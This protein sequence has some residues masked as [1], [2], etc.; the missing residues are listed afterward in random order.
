MRI[1]IIGAACRLPQSPGL[2][3]FGALLFAGRDAVGEVPPERWARGL[4]YHPTDG[5]PGKA[6]TTAAGCIDMVDQFDP[7]FFSISAREAAHIDPQQRLLL[8][9]AHEAIEDSGVPAARLGGQNV[10]V[11]VGGSSWDYSTIS[12]A[13]LTGTDNYSMQ[14][15][16]LSSMSNRLSYYFDLR[17]PSL[18]VDTAC[19]SSLVALH[20]ACESLRRSEIPTA[21]VGG[22]NLLLAPHPFV[23]FARAAMLSHRGRCQVFD[24]KADGY[25]RAEGGGAV[26][27]KPLRTALADG[28]PIRGV[29]LASGVNSDGRTNGFSVPSTRA[30]E[31]LLREVYARAGI[32]PDDVSYFE[33]HGTGTPV[34]DP[35][36]ANA[37]GRAVGQYRR[38]ALP[39]GSVKSNVGHLEAASGMAGLMKVI[40]SLARRE[41]PASLHFETPNP[42]IPF[43]ALNLDVVTAPRAM[44]PGAAGFVAGLN[45]FG[46]GG[47]NAHVVLAAPPEPRP[48]KAAGARPASLA[49]ALP[50]L[51]LSARAPEALRT[52]AQVWQGM[53]ANG[54]A[55]TLAPLLRGAARLRDHYPHRLT[56]PGAQAAAMAASLAGWLDNVPGAQSNGRAES[57]HA[58]HGRLAFVFSGNGSQWP[59]MAGD[60]I[61]HSAPFRK[62]LGTIDAV[63]MP[64]LGWS[65]RARFRQPAT[66]EDLRNS[67]IAQPMLFAVQLGC[68]AALRAHGIVAD[69]YV[70]HSVGEVAA[71][72]ASGAL[73]LQQAARVIVARSVAQQS[74]HGIGRMAVLDLGAEAAQDAIA[75]IAPA[76]TIAAVN[77]VRSVTVAGPEPALAKLESH[78]EA[79][80]WKYIALDLDYAFHSTLMDPIRDTLLADLAGLEPAT[81]TT[82]LVSTVTGQQVTEQSSDADYWWRNVR[83]P[84]RF[85]DA[86]ET[87]IGSGVH[88]FVEIG[89]RPV[90]QSYL[91]EAVTRSALPGRVLGTLTQSQ[92][93][94]DPF[95]AIA[96]RCYVAGSTLAGAPVFKGPATPR[97]LPLYPWQRERFWHERTPDA[98]EIIA[99]PHDHPLL[100]YRQTAAPG[101]WFSHL[102]TAT[103]P[104]L[105]DHVVDG[106]AVM[107][108]AAMIEMALAAG[109]ALH[110]DAAS[111]ELRDLEIIRT[112]PL[113]ASA[114]RQVTVRIGPGGDGFTIA[115]RPRLCGDAPTAHATGQVLRG[116]DT[117]TVFDAPAWTGDVTEIGAAAIYHAATAMRLTYGPAFR[118]VRLVLASGSAQAVVELDDG[119][120]DRVAEGY[121]IDPALVDGALQGLIGLASTQT[122]GLER[123]AMLP[124]RF[125]RVRLLRTDGARPVRAKLHLRRR[126][127]RA[128][129]ADIALL[130]ADGAVVMELLDCWFAVVNLGTTPD[131][132]ERMVWTALV[133]S[134]TQLAGSGVDLLNP[135]MDA[136]APAEVVPNS[137]MLADGM[138]ALAARAATEALLPADEQV[139]APGS[140]RLLAD[141]LRWL[142]QDGMACRE[143][144]FW[145]IATATDLPAW[146]NVWQ[147]LLFDVPA[148][149]ADTALAGVMAR[150]LGAIIT[151]GWDAAPVLPVT[152]VDQMLFASPTGAGAIDALLSAV[153]AWLDH[154]PASRPLR[155]AEIC[156]GWPSLTHRLLVLLARRVPTL[157]YVALT[158][159]QDALAAVAGTLGGWPGVTGRV[160]ERAGDD[161]VFDLVLGLYPFTAPRANAVT[162]AEAAALL[163][164]G[165]HLL[166]IEPTPSRLWNL[167]FG[168]EQS[169][170]GVEP[171]APETWQADLEAA[172]SGRTRSIVLAGGQLWQAALIGAWR[173]QESVAATPATRSNWTVFAAAGDAVARALAGMACDR[174][175]HDL[176]ALCDP[177]ALSALR[178]QLAGRDVVILFPE[179]DL[180]SDAV[181]DVGTLA[182]RLAML[183]SC[184]P[185]L[186]G[187]GQTRIWLVTR[188]PGAGAATGAALLGLLR[189]LANEMPELECCLLRLDPALSDEAASR[190]IAAEMTT[191]DAE[192]EVVWTPAGRFVRRLR[193]GSPPSDQDVAGATRLAVGRPG[194]LGSLRWEAFMPRVP[195]PNEVAIAVQ[196]AGLNFRDLMWAQGVL[197]EEALMGGFS[198]ASLG[199]ECAGVVTAVGPGVD[200]LMPGMRVIAVAPAALASE[201]VTL[202]RAVIPMPDNM[203]MAEG[204]TIPVAFMTAVYALGHLANLAPGERVLIHGGLGSLGLAAIQ[205]ALHRDAVV[206]ATAGSV[207]RRDLL[208]LLGVAGVFDSRHARFAD[209]V[210]AATG[211]EGVD[212]VLNSLSGELM[213]SGLRVLRP[214]GRFIE[215]GKRDLY[216]NTRLG[217]RSLRH[218][219]AYFAVDADE[220]AA[221]RPALAAAVFAEIT[222]LLSE[223]RLRPLPYRVYGSEDVVDAFRQLQGSGHLG[224]ILLTPRHAGVGRTAVQG[225]PIVAAP[226]T[227]FT[228]RADRTYVL[229]GAV[230]GFGLEA[231][232]FLARHGARHIALLGRRGQGTP[233]AEAALGRLRELGVEARIFAC[234]VADAEA[235][236]T[237]LIRIRAEMPPIAGV[238]HAAMVLDDAWA[239]DLDASRF[240]DVLRPKLGGAEALDRLTRADPLELFVLFSSI[241]TVLG[242]PGQANY[243]AANAAMEAVAERRRAEGLPALAVIWGPIGD[244]GYLTRAA[245][246]SEALERLLGN[247]HISAVAALEAL[248]ALLASGVAVCGLADLQWSALA[249]QM[250]G[251]RAPLLAET[252]SD[253]RAE[254]SGGAMRL[255]LAGLSP[256]E[257]AS[258]VLLVLVNEI[259]AILRIDP[260]RVDPDQVIAELGMDSLTSV[261][262]RL[263]L[264]ARLDMEIP[265]STLSSGGTLR[266]MSASIARMS[267]APA[268]ADEVVSRILQFEAPDNEPLLEAGH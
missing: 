3:A 251:L 65:V 249:R 70:G 6:Y 69:A 262:L 172:G 113:E 169:L 116:T 138:L 91:R 13:D 141:M 26:L 263:A 53:L 94:T 14:G 107:P 81:P 2:D 261:E 234:D 200:D 119:G 152:M 222:S 130:D 197:P 232:L 179:E 195:G 154:W 19:S 96:A 36:E 247:A 56:V 243:V 11:F 226:P 250:P 236:S 212:V 192:R 15:A 117:Q 230:G 16:A 193:G 35:L 208:E 133:P 196:V 4:F 214:F 267:A 103:D 137:V 259:S 206:Y 248:P 121:L 229:S 40:V 12:A 51:L 184:L 77:S 79:M 32:T 95:A 68:V 268:P 111:L 258:T 31:C 165:G 256:E 163:A 225:T 171:S 73:D 150:A 199:L 34:G 203:N 131:P 145:R 76:L 235:L 266:A 176:A 124:W 108:A 18:T 246:V 97:G 92:A 9:L 8:E 156:V 28:D 253:G 105:Q 237:S 191:H 93:E 238:I 64:L 7:A 125:G 257:A 188:D 134:R 183:T 20:L 72:W 78:A 74:R 45:S 85:S 260:E 62:M 215:V 58:V 211:G 231:A 174:A 129:L 86:I 118:T 126:G 47:T 102:S 49:R 157:R 167:V 178:G 24:A 223:G 39:I 162:P 146:P 90:L 44:I 100:G 89:P 109:R 50:P 71:A 101:A 244:A 186:G 168:A 216:G 22:V 136:I 17:G 57:G 227:A 54:P 201:V 122:F 240:A 25:V 170:A 23:G 175:I 128:L 219:I 155:V 142:E 84:V 242:N 59:G 29:I 127:V 67:A 181:S 265:I 132:A 21:L 5:Q 224:K 189:T 221:Q 1:A 38:T 10:G 112:L 161:E 151:G 52:L 99:P 30:Q 43:A 153:D 82:L 205:Y 166:V 75:R 198:G 187:S 245:R 194:L 139:L 158:G 55:E 149:A 241:T 98:H 220:L 80:G 114:A 204:A 218:N 180:R 87:L 46:F 177:S 104:W 209:D 88:L 217:L 190:L 115:S 41:I 202:R 252:P 60:A 233:G 42:H 135:V 239:K 147:S 143:G 83:D 159:G 27:L 148:A 182:A 173:D 61:A 160:R 140:N 110:P 207:L 164:P 254:I 120:A 228:V 123:A 264:E 210:M 66:A 33:A 213:E 185:A 255:M 106:A 63:L 144:A 48:G 37:V